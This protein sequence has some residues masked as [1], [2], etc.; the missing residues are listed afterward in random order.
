MTS[1]IT[2]LQKDE[3]LKKII[4]KTGKI[5]GR[6]GN[7][8][9]LDL[10]RAIVGQQLS[11]KAANTIWSRFVALFPDNYPGPE[12][13]LS[14]D[15]NRMRGA[16]LSFQKAGYLQNIARFALDPGLDYKEL[17]TKKDEELIIHLTSIKGVGRWTAEMLLMFTLNRPDVFPLDDL[18]IQTSMKMHYR[19]RQ[20][21]RKRLYAAMEKI[22]ERWRPYRTL[23]CMYL[24]RSKDQAA[25]AK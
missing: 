19:L 15:V 25:A 11:V 23:A 1:A 18:G 22:A 2:H 17:K 24:W 4:G 16:G 12:A 6:R 5:R 7:D 20:K 21:D 3:V 8:L 14:M 13:V 9:Y 10:L